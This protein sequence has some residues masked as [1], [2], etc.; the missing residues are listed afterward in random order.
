MVSFLVIIY[1][2]MIIA[3]TLY[4]MYAGFTSSLPWSHCG[5]GSSQYCYSKDQDLACL[6]G[7]NH[8]EIYYNGSCVDRADV[9]KRFNADTLNS[10]HCDAG[11]GASILPLD[12]KSLLNRRTASE[13]YFSH[14]MLRLKDDSTW[15]NMGQF[16]PHLIITLV[17]AWFFVFISLI[18]GVKSSGKVV[19]FTALY[20]YAILIILFVRGVT[21]PGAV[22]GI[23]W[24]I[25]PDWDRLL[26]IG[27]WG[28]AA[29]QLFYSLGMSFGTLL[30]FAS[31][32]R[33]W[34]MG[35]QILLFLPLLGLRIIVLEM[36][37][38]LALLIV[39]HQFSL[40]LLSS[41]L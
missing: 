9:C 12:L 29:T 6:A 33:W 24:Y 32:N 41:P 19:Y 21:L 36:H 17:I 40:A 30:T 2:N 28:D 31:Y 20:P 34:R 38:L 22:D 16:Q 3:W 4:Y 23:Q 37:Y 15:E 14:Q 7:S 18:K 5:D 27:P 39:G 26:E 25:T 35:N 13:D 1:Y 8:T 11:Y 10:T